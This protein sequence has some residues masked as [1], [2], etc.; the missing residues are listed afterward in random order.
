[1]KR[2]EKRLATRTGS[3]RHDQERIAH[4]FALPRA[5][6]TA[7]SGSGLFTTK[8]RRDMEEGTEKHRNSLRALLGDLP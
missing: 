6:A 4:R 7:K 3:E 1:V 2:G 8:S 5:A